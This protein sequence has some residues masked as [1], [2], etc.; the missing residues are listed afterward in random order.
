MFDEISR[1]LIFSLGSNFLA[2]I[3]IE[4]VLSFIVPHAS[5][6]ILLLLCYVHH[7]ACRGSADQ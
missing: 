6:F 5:D 3:R 7:V 4:Q 2:A 1:T